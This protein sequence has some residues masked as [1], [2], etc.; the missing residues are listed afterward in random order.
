MPI[1]SDSPDGKTALVTG[2]G[3]GLGRA[4][5]AG[6]AQPAARSPDELD[7]TAGPVRELGASALVVPADVSDPRFTSSHQQGN[8]ISPQQSAQSLLAHL[9]TDATGRIWTAS[10]P[11]WP[12]V[13]TPSNV[14]RPR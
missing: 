10:G 8:L 4:I 2:A 12:S 13:A 5:A 3:R 11:A 7:Q 6:L 1:S 14:G 9:D